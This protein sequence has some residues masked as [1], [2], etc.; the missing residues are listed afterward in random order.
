MYEL[1]SADDQ[2]KQLVEKAIDRVKM[3]TKEG[4]LLPK[5]SSLGSGEQ[6]LVPSD[7]AASAEPPGAIVSR[8]G[9]PEPT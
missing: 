9:V 4:E 3:R 8:P 2:E 6:W 1:M 5:E 7:E